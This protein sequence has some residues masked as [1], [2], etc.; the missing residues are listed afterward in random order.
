[1]SFSTR[2]IPL[3]VEVITV[4]DTTNYTNWVTVLDL[5]SQSLQTENNEQTTV[6]TTKEKTQSFPTCLDLNIKENMPQT[7]RNIDRKGMT[8]DEI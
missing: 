6:F 4:V 5:H 8:K 2:V 7:Q 1:M 3:F